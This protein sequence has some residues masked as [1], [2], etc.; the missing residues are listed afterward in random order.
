M[1]LIPLQLTKQSLLSVLS[2]VITLYWN[3]TS[4]LEHPFLDAMTRTPMTTFN[5]P[6]LHV[7]LV[8]RME[9]SA[10]KVEVANL[11]RT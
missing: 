2:Y 1:R 5:K 8:V 6:I 4:V 7:G 10:L 3:T 11:R 9:K